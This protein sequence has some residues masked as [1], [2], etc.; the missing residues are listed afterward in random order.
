MLQK[1]AGYDI[2]IKVVFSDG[3]NDEFSK[4]D[5]ASL[6]LELSGSAKCSA[7]WTDISKLC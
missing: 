7:H 1:K 4:N 2:I 3:K 6:V 5:S